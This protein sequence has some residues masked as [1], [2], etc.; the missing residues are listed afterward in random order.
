MSGANTQTTKETIIEYISSNS[1]MSEEEAA[2]LLENLETTNDFPQFKNQPDTSNM[3]EKKQM[4]KL[5]YAAVDSAREMV[6]ITDAREEIGQ[7]EIIYANRG[8]EEITGYTQEE[9][10]GNNPKMLQ[11]PETDQSEIDRLVENLSNGERFTGETFNYRKDGT[12]YRVRWS[13]DPIYND[14]GDIT[15]FVSLQQNVTEEWE[16]KKK[17]Q[18]IIEERESLLS[19]IH[20]RLKNNLAVI[21]GLL[22]LQAAKTSSEETKNILSECINRIQSIATLHEKLYETGDFENISLNSYITELIEHLVQTLSSHDM[23]ISIRED[24]ADISLP[25]DKA[26]TLALIINEVF[27]NSFKHGFKGVK[28]GRLWITLNHESDHI[29]LTI[30][31]DGVGLPDDLDLANINTLGMRLIHTL[32][33]QLGGQYTFENRDPGTT[34][35]LEFEINRG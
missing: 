32:C 34:F 5:L 10:I 3:I 12:T 27:T 29:D 8:V 35:F 20:H 13:I 21:I 9:L 18:Q 4:L 7:E 33:T 15:H 26:V 1:D 11:G 16:R 25:S 14:D 28:E 31:D 19:E 30:S 24:I 2:D 6:I 17:L 23:D 22:D